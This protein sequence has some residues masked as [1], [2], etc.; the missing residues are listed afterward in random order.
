MKSWT[1]YSEENRLDTGSTTRWTSD[2]GAPLK[3]I[4]KDLNIGLKLL[5][6]VRWFKVETREKDWLFDAFDVDKKQQPILSLL[7]YRNQRINR[8]VVWQ[9][10]RLSRIRKNK[11]AKPKLFW[12][13]AWTLMKSKSF[14]T[15]ALNSI[16]TNWY[17]TMP[18][19]EVLK[20]AKEVREI[21][22]QRKDFMD[23]KRVYIEKANGKWRP[24]GCP[25]PAWRIFLHMYTLIL[26]LVINSS[27]APNQHAYVPGRGVLTAWQ[28]L[29]EKLNT[30]E[31]IYEFDLKGF[32][33]NVNTKAVMDVLHKD[34]NLPY[35]ELVWFAHLLRSTPKLPDDQKMDESAIIQKKKEHEDFKKVLQ[36]L[37]ERRRYRPYASLFRREWEHNYM[38][39]QG[40]I[41]KNLTPGLPQGAP[42]SPL[43]SIM[44]LQK[45]IDSNT[46]MYADDGIIFTPRGSE[47]PEFDRVK[48][49]W[50]GVEINREKSGWVKRSGEWIKPLKF[51]G[52]EYD[53]KTYKASTRKG[54]TL[55][56]TD[57]KRFMIWLAE[58]WRKISNKN[59]NHSIN[60]KTK[61]GLEATFK[62]MFE[63]YKG[64]NM[65]WEQDFKSRFTGF[66]FSRLQ[67]GDW[68]PEVV[69]EFKLRYAKKSLLD[70]KLAGFMRRKCI[71][72]QL[73]LYNASTFANNCL[74]NDLDVRYS[75]ERNRINTIK[76]VGIRLLKEWRPNKLIRW[77]FN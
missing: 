55:E 41:K 14:Q 11:A 53:G 71:K 25:T 45:V 57:E 35:D 15:L 60:P 46:I 59:S 13:I 34:F 74:I 12:I 3:S 61:Q 69:Q 47:I 29:T 43:L 10:I 67:G 38:L 23:F 56:W 17:K 68:N 9:M 1:Q 37:P 19:W 40:R 4:V 16:L 30:D 65:T 64:K 21:V 52:I 63:D 6:D 36:T 49:E 72:E 70:Q 7:P 39:F 48:S 26:Q 73:T 8:Y 44:P 31:D 5:P 76:H 27:V 50:A 42:F 51:L 2:A 28:Q 62:E 77:A 32:F 33:D 54:S 58:N 18:Y 24:L 75:L 22:H 66:V 20:I